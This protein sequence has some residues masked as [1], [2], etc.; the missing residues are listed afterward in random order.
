MDNPERNR[1]SVS[2]TKVSILTSTMADND[3][4]WVYPRGHTYQPVMAEFMS[5]LHGA[6][7]YDNDTVFTRAQ[8]LEI[9]P[10]DVKR[11]LCMKAY[12]DPDPNIE[13]G[14]RPTEG[15]SDSLYYVKKAL[16]K[17]MPHRT[18]NWINGQGNPTKSALVNDMIKQV[19]KFEVRGEGAPSNAKRPLKQVEFRKTITLFRECNDWVHQWRYPMMAL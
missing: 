19:K 14:A 15:R 6:E 11:F 18:A 3:D 7:E 2:Q 13:G 8:L 9:R 10:T 4:G 12:G 5:F 16:S 1:G 17:Y